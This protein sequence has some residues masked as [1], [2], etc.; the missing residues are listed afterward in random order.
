MYNGATEVCIH[1]ANAMWSAE[2]ET[3]NFCTNFR[4]SWPISILFTP[5]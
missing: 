5:Y 1:N 3:I 2:N 4:K